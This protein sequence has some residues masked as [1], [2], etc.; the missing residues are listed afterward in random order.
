M[1]ANLPYEV[2]NSFPAFRK[3]IY[4]NTATSGLLSEGLFQWRQAHDLD[5]MTRG[6]EMKTKTDSLISGVRQSVGN[7][8]GCDSENVAL[9]P[10][11][12]IGL[13]LL[14]EGLRDTEKVL[15]LNRDYPSL[16]WP[17][18]HRNF[19]FLKIDITKNLEETI[20]YN[21]KQNGITVLACSLVQWLNGFKIDINFYKKLKQ[22]FPDLLIIVDGTQY[23]GTEAFDFSSSGIDILGSSGYKW[24]LSGYGNGFLLVNPK[25]TPRFSLKAMGYG[26]GRN[27]REYQKER[28]FCKHLEPG[29][30]AALNF[31]SLGYSLQW[32]MELGMD[33]IGK[34]LHALSSRARDEFN[35][36]GLLDPIVK[37]RATH[38]TIFNLA[39]DLASHQQL[40]ANNIVCVRRGEGTRLGFHLYNTQ[41]DVD[42]IVEILKS[43]G[44]FAT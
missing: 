29:H 14:L 43:V 9:V 31:G 44:N 17:F 37:E 18:Q 42:A 3:R 26:S 20:Y 22:D 35:A 8:F 21:V 4:V 30:L 11:F 23:C 15:L 16:N 38:S 19:S 1:A 40:L 34:H 7:C 24:L 41:E 39:I 12:S 5:Y 36:L 33:R 6:S 13:N 10:S 2:R 25:A 32:L 28:T 27:A